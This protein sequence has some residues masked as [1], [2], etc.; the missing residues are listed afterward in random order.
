MSGICF[1]SMCKSV[2]GAATAVAIVILLASSAAAQEASAQKEV[3]VPTNAQAAIKA[4]QTG[5]ELDRVV[6]VVN[7]DLILESDVDEERRIAAFQPFHDKRKSFERDAA[8]Q[9]LIDRMLIL[10]QAKLQPEDQVSDQAIDSEFSVLRK[11]IPACKSYHCDSDEGWQR[12][13]ADQGFTME[14][15]RERWRERM[16]VLRFIEVRF[17]MG[18]HITDDEIR[19]Y[20][21]QTLV[22]QYER[23][24]AVAP[25]LETITDRV[26]EILLQQRVGALLGDWLKTLR[27]Q[28]TVRMMTADEVA[29]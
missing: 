1:R 14:E 22:P 26:Q 28:G 10:Q 8:I 11:D 3:A 24:K 6:A 17:R 15:L 19:A 20:Y 23:Q 29:P 7:G 9:R 21:D 5:T 25:K 18:I 12:F 4:G 16:E 2:R 27:A 13:V